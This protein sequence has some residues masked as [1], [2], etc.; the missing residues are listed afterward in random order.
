MVLEGCCIDYEIINIGLNHG[1]ADATQHH[2]NQEAISLRGV[3]QAKWHPTKLPIGIP[4][5][6]SRQWPVSSINFNVMV[7]FGPVQR[8]INLGFSKLLEVIHDDG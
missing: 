7:G 3:S 5:E 6:E 4:V 8:G 1:T 2:L